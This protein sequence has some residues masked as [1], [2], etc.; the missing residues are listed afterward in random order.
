MNKKT[1][2]GII[3][4]LILTLITPTLAIA[5]SQN[6]IPEQEA[7]IIFF[8]EVLQLIMDRYPFE[9]KE[10][11]LIEAALRG[12]LQSLDP[13]SDYY[14]KEEAESMYGNLLG[15]FSGI[16]VH[17]EEKDGYINVVK[18]LKGQP[19]EKA[20]L[21]KDDLI[22]SVDDIDIKDIGLTK[23]SAMIKG[24]KDTKVK[25]GI[26]RGEKL[27][28]IEVTRKIILINP[29]HYEI[30]EK[31]I[32][33][34]QLDEFNTQTTLEINKA[35]KEFDNKR[36]KKII[37]DLRDN[38]GGLLDQAISASK[39]FVPRGPIVH[40]RE[41]GKALVTHTSTLAK[42]KYKLVVLVNENS[43]SASEIFAGA[44]K[45]RKVGTLVGTKTFG[46]GLVQSIYPI[47]DGSMIKLTIAEYLTP[48]KISINGK[49]I[50]PDILVENTEEDLQLLKAIEILK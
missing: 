13:Y 22:I 14:T 9:A 2:S 43:A 4:I 15:T 23:V 19:A 18:I 40:V 48:N 7:D 45:D 50:E 46:K 35:L 29:V 30:L 8:A 5:E 41:K 49:G 36:I 20:G 34:I 11:D 42:S 37:L 44:I 32:G 6:Q 26:K 1:L 21:K 16:G 38:P 47:L 31:D 28:T 17:I 24:P 33:Y 10:S 25:L 27:L 12:M 3:F 39:L